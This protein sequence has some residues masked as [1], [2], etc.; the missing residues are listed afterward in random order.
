MGGRWGVDG[1][2]KKRE[3]GEGER[4]GEGRREEERE[5]RWERWER[6]GWWG[7]FG[8]DRDGDEGG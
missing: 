8:G 6:D 7:C 5:E 4:G 1:G 2:L 3:G